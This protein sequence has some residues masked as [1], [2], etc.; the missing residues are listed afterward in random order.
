MEAETSRGLPH[1]IADTVATTAQVFRAARLTFRPV[2][3]PLCL[4]WVSHSWAALWHFLCPDICI[5]SVRYL[6]RS[7]G[8]IPVTARP[9]CYLSVGL[10]ASHTGRPN[11]RAQLFWKFCLHAVAMKV[12]ASLLHKRTWIIWERHQN[13]HPLPPHIISIIRSFLPLSRTPSLWGC[14]RKIMLWK[15]RIASTRFLRADNV[16]VPFVDTD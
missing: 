13:K 3:C 1:W 16:Q 4:C 8:R 11:H 12:F 9:D 15:L 10:L 7:H 14:T 5:H 6:T 2:I